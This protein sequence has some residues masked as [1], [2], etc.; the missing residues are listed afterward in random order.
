MSHRP[1][2]AAIRPLT[3]TLTLALLVTGC[4]FIGTAH[5]RLEKTDLT[6]AA[7]P[8]IDSAGFLIALNKGLFSAAGLHVTFKPVT[9]S[10]SAIADQMKGKYDISAGNYVSYIQAQENHT[11]DLRI[12]AEGSVMMP[13]SQ[14]VYTMPGSR[15]RTLADLEGKTVG[16]NAPKNIC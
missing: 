5:Q 14:A 6:V 11:A 15:I 16:V 13:G 4:S 9:S 1:R 12:V 3:L 10:E 7:V 2:S 8:A